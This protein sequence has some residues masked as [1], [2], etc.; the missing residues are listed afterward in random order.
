MVAAARQ[1]HILREIELRG[2]V[3]VSALSSRFGV[4]A[5]TTRRDLA[6]LELQG[7]LVRVHGGAMASAG[8]PRAERGSQQAS[9]HALATIGMIVPTSQ[10]YFSAIIRGAHAAAREAR[11]RLVLAS[12]HYSDADELRQAER[13]LQL[14]VDALLV[15]PARPLTDDD[16]HGAA[17]VARLE[18]AGIPIV[19]VER[20]LPMAAKLASVLE[21]ARSDHSLGAELAV[22]HL[23]SFDRGAIAL[24]TLD[25]PTAPALRDGFSRA[26]TRHSLPEGAMVE[27][28]RSDDAADKARQVLR[29]LVDLCLAQGITNIVV[30]PDAHALA[31]LDV[32]SE[33]NLSCPEDIKIVAYDD[34]VAALARVPLTSVSP[35]KYELGQTAIQMCVRR[36]QLGQDAQHAVTHAVLAPRLTVRAST[37]AL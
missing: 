21:S 31:L 20:E 35:P 11:C 37:G 32:L 13:M 30:Q 6:E 34:E 9:F 16:A 33:R 25:T 19:I 14:G 8:S 4:S 10:Y 2:S 15:T 23:A 17:F 26:T 7:R 12:S 29:D 28:P 3:S 22:E 18:S 24:A 36:L 5:M 1:D 27:L